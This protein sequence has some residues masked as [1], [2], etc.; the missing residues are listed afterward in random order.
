[1]IPGNQLLFLADQY[2]PPIQKLVCVRNRYQSNRK[3]G[4]T[5]T[6]LSFIHHPQTRL[7]DYD[8][9]ANLLSTTCFM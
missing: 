2:R 4:A 7:H 5:H 6:E 1:M 9:E 3:R 8:S